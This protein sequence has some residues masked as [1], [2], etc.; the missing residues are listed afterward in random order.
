VTGNMTDA[1]T[2][3]SVYTGPARIAELARQLAGRPLVALNHYLNPEWMREAC[4]R[5]RKD[6][7][8]GVDGMVWEEYSRNLPERLEEL[9]NRAKAGDRYRAPAVRRVYIPK[10]KGQTR[11]LGIPMVCS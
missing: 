2:S 4:R 6:A 11:P 9:L 3:E 7:A 8:P 10:G 1:L 5:T